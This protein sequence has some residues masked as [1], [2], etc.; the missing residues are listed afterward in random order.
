MEFMTDI[1]LEGV[2][3]Y[4]NVLAV[5]GG[6]PVSALGGAVWERVCACMC[7]SHRHRTKF[8][9][10]MLSLPSAMMQSLYHET[11]AIIWFDLSWSVLCEYTKEAECLWSSSW[12][13]KTHRPRIGHKL[14]S[15]VLYR[16]H[17]SSGVCLTFMIW[18]CTLCH[19][20]ILV[21]CVLLDNQL[22]SVARGHVRVRAILSQFTWCWDVSTIC[23][24]F[25]A[26]TSIRKIR[27][28]FAALQEHAIGLHDGVLCWHSL[29]QQLYIAIGRIRRAKIYERWVISH[30]DCWFF[31]SLALLNLW[32]D[33]ALCKGVEGC[34]V[35]N[36]LEYGGHWTWHPGE[37][38]VP[39]GL[40][41]WGK[42]SIF[43]CPVFTTPW[44]LKRLTS[45]GCR[46]EKLP[47]T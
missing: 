43:W 14:L 38:D 6:L 1:F 22:L 4:Q 5:G 26:F 10:K 30:T 35:Q 19:C 17:S 16:T 46:A 27:N 15:A 13:F 42:P 3:E 25:C 23:T 41:S 45:S 9:S 29:W 18:H 12:P 33:N 31:I 32:T 20:R 44:T 2:L 40:W 34:C 37:N 28:G 47:K 36:A 21:G 7:V 8:R 11:K 24:R 39:S